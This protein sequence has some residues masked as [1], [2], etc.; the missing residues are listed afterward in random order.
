MSV[1]FIRYKY[2]YLTIY[3]KLAHSSSLHTILNAYK[4]YKTSTALRTSK[5]IEGSHRNI[6]THKYTNEG[7]YANPRAGIFF[8]PLLA[9]NDFD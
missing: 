4:K 8:F 9:A 7:E 2:T 5:R 1:G 3:R 6:H